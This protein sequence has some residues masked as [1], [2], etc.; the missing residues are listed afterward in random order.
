MVA[1]PAVLRT[2]A[3]GPLR[4]PG[5]FTLGTLGAL[6]VLGLGAPPAH[7][8]PASL[9][10]SAADPGD[11]VD[12]HLR[13]DYD[14]A[15]E[16]ATIWR[17][18]V[19]APGANP[20]DP[21]PKV[22]DLA[23]K[24][25]RHQLVPRA[26]LGIYHNTSISVALPIIIAQQRELTLAPGVTRDG[27]TTL[28]DGLLPMEGFDARDPGTG[29]AGDGVF[30]GVSRSGVDQ[31]HTGMTFALMNQDKDDTKPTWKLG[32]ELRIP[33]GRVMRM[34][35]VDPSL[36]T[37]VGRGVYEV[38]V[39]TSVARRYKRTEGWFELY[40]Q[41]PLV[42]KDTALLRLPE[43]ERFGAT[44]I[45]PSQR[46]GVGFGLEV[47]AVDDRAS[48]NR[49]SLDLGSRIDAHFE[50]RGYSEMW[51]VFAYAGYAGGAADGPLVLDADPTTSAREA[52]SHPGI[53][54][55][56]NYLELA[57]RAAI[58]AQLGRHV[59][60]AATLDLVWK[61]DHV[62]SFADAG[63]DLPTCDDPGVG[64]PCEGGEP[65]T[66][67]SRGTREVNPLHD[68]DID[69]VGHRYHAEDGFGFAIGVQGQILF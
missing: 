47:Y 53:S 10:A 38:R 49:V 48:G 57:G 39:S 7:G 22:S 42:A 44:N 67:V 3:I 62:I 37:G 55:I 46:A 13:L 61:T 30:R 50:G 12:L 5:M 33:V 15:V 1:F 25:S 16:T 69:L 68:D 29:L 28:V 19:G 34:N 54:N 35:P 8:N 51:E 31:I 11:P 66:V 17:E 27:S 32:G 63:V 21:L 64:S 59:R 26:D 41:A 52:R 18:V 40:W 36:E 24:Q 9:V 60:F 6:G 43:A 2:G 14:Y 20:L 56:E 65:N 23:F 4:W 45:D 58:R